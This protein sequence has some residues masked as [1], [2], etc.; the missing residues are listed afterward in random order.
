MQGAEQG[1]RTTSLFALGL[2]LGICAA[3]ALSAGHKLLIGGSENL[4][5]HQ[6]AAFLVGRLDVSAALQDAALFQGKTY[7][8]FPP[9]PALLLVP[10]VA[11]LGVEHVPVVAI[12]L[13]L[14]G[15][16]SYALV[17][18]LQSLGVAPRWV[19]IA[20]VGFFFG[21]AYWSA[22]RV[23]ERVW[24][25][26]H[27]VAV[28]FGLLALHQAL[29]QRSGVLSGLFLSCAFLS[30]QMTIYWAP[31]LAIAL[32]RA[33]AENA[34]QQHRRLIAF[35]AALGVG[36]GAYLAFNF[37]RFGDPFEAG[38]RYIPLTGHLAERV[39][40]YGLFHPAY[41]PFNATYLFLQGF[42]L[43]FAPPDY[44]HVKGLDPFGTSL[45]A[46]SPFVFAALG[47]RWERP[48]IAGAWASMALIVAHT[49]LYHNNGMLQWNAQRFTLDFLPIT[50]LLVALGAPYCPRF[51][52]GTTFYAVVLNA[53]SLLAFQR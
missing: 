48:M 42:H 34:K 30:R 36:V 37:A 10:A 7:V 43:E 27:I 14:T 5:A 31:F 13:V 46:A 44:L 21:T 32:W 33:E 29:V 6:A 17:R 52:V 8:P 41:I 16:G 4:Y 20:A 18:T 50:T 12:A 26:A 51:L 35:I 22:L 49:L 2:S 24:F 9:L 40:R 11:L 25:F 15:L 45:F 53:F 38:Y 19:I 1:Q 3:L 39:N 28:T 23:S 47:A